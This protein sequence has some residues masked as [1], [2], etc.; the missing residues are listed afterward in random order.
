MKQSDCTPHS[1]SS[2]TPRPEPAGACENENDDIDFVETDAGNIPDFASHNRTDESGRLPEYEG[3]TEDEPETS[4]PPSWENAAVHLDELRKRIV[5]SLAVFIPLFGVGLWLYRDLWRIIILPLN[6]AAPHLARFQALGPSDGLVMA[7]RIAF[8]FALFVS[9]PMWLAQIWLFVAPGLTDRERRLVHL[10]IG[11]GGILFAIGATLAYFAAIPYAL[12]YLLP[13]NQTL[14][15]W[16]NAFTGAGYV[17]F[18]ITCCFGFGIAFELPLAM[19]ALGWAGILTPAGLRQWWRPIILVIFVLAAVMTPP[20][21][22][23]QMLLAIPLLA[24]FFIGY[25]LVKWTTSSTN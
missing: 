24:L 16:E 8:A 12:E 2:R 18:V 15:G 14:Q 23:T 3:M 7:M 25:W 9:L 13:F 6:R 19:L 22:F 4:R 5:L 21:P 1:E 11:S 10:S 20:D 17:D